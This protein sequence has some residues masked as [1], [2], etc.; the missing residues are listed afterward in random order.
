MHRE[1]VLFEFDRKAIIA[2]LLKNKFIDAAT[3]PDLESDE[4][5]K[6]WFINHIR[7]EEIHPFSTIDETK[8]PETYYVYRLIH[9]LLVVG[10]DRI[11]CWKR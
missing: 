7:P 2:W 5:C 10:R 6:L 1:G 9:P 4:E 3:A 8:T 11:C